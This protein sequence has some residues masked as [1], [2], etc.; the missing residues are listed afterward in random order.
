VP[1]PNPPT[2]PTPPSEDIDY[3]FT[4]TMDSTELNIQ[5]DKEPANVNL[6]SEI[7]ITSEHSWTNTV[8]YEAQ[9]S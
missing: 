5:F 1:Q 9:L 3:T 4:M 8:D 7:L 6:D 2:P